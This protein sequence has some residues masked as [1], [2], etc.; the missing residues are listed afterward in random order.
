MADNSG[1]PNLLGMLSRHR[2]SVVVVAS[3]IL[4]CDFAWIIL[5][6]RTYESVAK[7][8]VRLGR[9]NVALDPTATY[10][11]TLNLYAT[12]EHEINSVLQMLESQPIAEQVVDR[13][14]AELVLGKQ[15]ASKGIQ[16]ITA[17]ILGRGF[18][19]LAQGSANLDPESVRS[20]AIRKLQQEIQIWAPVNSSVVGIRCEAGDPAVAQKV[21]RA[22]TDVFLKE[23]LRMT[24][25]EGSYEFFGNE[26]SAAQAT[27]DAAARS[28]QEAKDAAGLVS[29]VGQQKI[30]E[31]QLAAIELQ[32]TRNELAVESS[33]AK[34]EDLRRKLDSL[35]KTIL[36]QE[37]RGAAHEAWDG[38]REK[39]YELQIQQQQLAAKYT[40]AHPAMVAIEE[41][42]REVRKILELQAQTRDTSVTAPNPTY[43]LLHQSLLNE[44]A[45]M[46]GYRAER[47]ELDNQRAALAADLQR[48][49]EAA[50]CIV[51]LERQV[52]ICEAKYRT[53]VEKMEQARIHQALDQQRVSSVNIVQPAT[54]IEKPVAPNKRLS[55]AAGLFFA[56]LGGAFSAI[57]LEYLTPQAALRETSQSSSAGL[58]RTSVSSV[59]QGE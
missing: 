8:Y 56:A 30:L 43:Q 38:M 16:P 44:E 53:S 33:R 47:E 48:L 41:Q 13:L 36:A 24:R 50:V 34:L 52:A 55:L 10:G 37:S 45:Q 32:Q 6:P 19:L 39:L 31:D 58:A 35:P 40:E 51:A 1:G 4:A 49:N 12:Q 3:L 23:H 28:L 22:W 57:A 14:G 25:T 15:P 21:V 11:E 42:V 26:V 18:A 46:N 17:S 27:L 59:R 7:L 54:F 2:R 9:E 29:V 20:R 5:G